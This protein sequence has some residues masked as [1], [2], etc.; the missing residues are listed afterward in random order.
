VLYKFGNILIL[1]GP[2]GAGKTATVKVL[3]KELRC[4]LQE[5]SNPIGQDAHHQPMASEDL[6]WEHGYY[7]QYKES[8]TKQFTNFIFRSDRYGMLQLSDSDPQPGRRKI[9][10]VEVNAETMMN[11][12][13]VSRNDISNQDI[14]NAFY[15]QPDTLWPILRKYHQT[16]RCPL[17]F[18]VSDSVRGN[19][20]VTKLFPGH[21]Q[22]ELEVDVINFNPI[23]TTNMTKALTKIITMESKQVR[24]SIFECLGTDDDCA[25]V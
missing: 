8:Q 14:P 11:A 23:A 24:Q 17:V 20:S 2:P 22:R 21:V 25:Y 19:N 13:V 5:W 3:V 4:H 6:P 16:G 7:P 18:I 9:I 1:T 10:L 12:L 15:R